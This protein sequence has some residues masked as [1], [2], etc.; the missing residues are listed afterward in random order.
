MLKDE[1]VDLIS[2]K[3]QKKNRVKDRYY[4]VGYFDKNGIA[5]GDFNTE[6]IGNIKD[7]HIVVGKNHKNWVIPS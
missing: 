1:N 3:M 2:L 6:I 5:E 4:V 7:L